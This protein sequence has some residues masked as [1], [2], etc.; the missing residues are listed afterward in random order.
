MVATTDTD[1]TEGS[2]CPPILTERSF[3]APEMGTMIHGV[4]IQFMLVSP[5]SRSSILLSR[6]ADLSENSGKKRK[7]NRL[8]LKNSSTFHFSSIGIFPF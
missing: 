3:C 7:I 2:A 5:M 4:S 8:A 1:S 6:L